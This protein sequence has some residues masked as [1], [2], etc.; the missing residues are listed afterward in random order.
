MTTIY[1]R[2]LVALFP[3]FIYCPFA[4]AQGISLE[5]ESQELIQGLDL[6]QFED[7]KLI[8]Y[9]AM[10]DSFITNQ[11]GLNVRAYSLVEPGT[12]DV[13]TAYM[14]YFKQSEDGEVLGMEDYLG[15]YS[16]WQNKEFSLPDIG[17]EAIGTATIFV[18]VAGAKEYPICGICL[19]GTATMIY[20]PPAL[21]G[22]GGTWA[23]FVG[24]HGYDK[25][26]VFEE[27]GPDAVYS[28]TMHAELMINDIINSMLHKNNLQ[29]SFVPF[30]G[31]P[32]E[33]VA[34][35]IKASTIVVVIPSEL[36][37]DEANVWDSFEITVLHKSEPV[38]NNDALE[39][40]GIV[41]IDAMREVQIVVSSHRYA[42]R[43]LW[44]GRSVNAPRPDQMDSVLSRPA[45]VAMEKVFAQR[46][47]Q[48]A[49]WSAMMATSAQ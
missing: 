24:I 36:F 47:G 35:D 17:Q 33:S 46:M 16:D 30:I 22:T 3:F 2:S 49:L 20:S 18:G 23:E 45:A 31:S 15:A 26:V 41:R 8:D 38:T 12:V 5:M 4:L 13:G 48:T 43:G 9:Q 27:G 42:K 44:I 37:R 14:D 19:G 29:Q 28:H 25:D 32:T 39:A 11:S 6:S 1:I 40:Y 21:K 10:P 7:R 34:W